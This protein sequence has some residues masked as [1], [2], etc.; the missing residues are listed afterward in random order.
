[1]KKNYRFERKRC[2]EYSTLKTIKNTKNEVD[3]VRVV[4]DSVAFSL[5]IEPPICFLYQTILSQERVDQVHCKF[6]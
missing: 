1:M 2:I 4:A 5:S 3:S 6:A